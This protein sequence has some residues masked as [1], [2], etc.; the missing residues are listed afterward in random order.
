M[1]SLPPR[2]LALV[3]L[4]LAALGL[5]FWRLGAMPLF[6]D[7]AFYL[8]WADRL[9]PA[10]FDHPAGIAWLLKLSTLLGGQNE[11]GVRW[12]NALLG[13]ACV[14]LVYA[15]GRRYVSA[16]GGLIAAAAVAFGPVYVVTGRVVY[17]DALHA[18]LL[19]VNLLTL[20]P[21]FSGDRPSLWRWVWGGLALALLLNVKLSSGFYAIALGLYLLGWR[22]DLLRQPGLWLMAGVAGLG[23]LPI[24]G[25][26]LAHDWA[27]IRWAIF[28][29]QGFGLPQPGMRASLVHAWRVVTP[30]AVLLAGLAAATWLAA[31]IRQGCRA[32]ATHGRLRAPAARNPALLAVV[33][34]CLLLPI[35]LSAADSPRNLGVGL[36]AVWPLAG[37]SLSRPD[38]P[39]GLA[40]PGPL[41]YLA[42]AAGL[43]LGLVLA[44]YGVG[45]LAALLGPTRLPHNEA[46]A[47]IRA[48]AAG[49]PQFAREVSLSADRVLFAVDYSIAGQIAHYTGRPVYTAAQ[50]FQ[51]W[52]IPEFSDATVFAM[53]FIP[54]Q[55]ITDRL[56]EDFAT[57]TGPETWTYAQD[58]VAKPVFI[59]RATGRRAAMEQV[60]ADLDY[61]TLVRAARRPNRAQE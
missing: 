16:W 3:A 17:P 60:I 40:K 28:Q 9:A 35:L 43:L 51:M 21:L 44:L 52:G 45:T 48:D 36:L 24:I 15:V 29:G 10:Y 49:W 32:D 47:A 1:K 26:N 12:L 56:A 55:L 18:F 53:S 11:L 50:Q 38:E 20:A 25:W 39:G 5:R 30:P 22:R 42:H 7:E 54:P 2:S 14:P 34:A 46:S 8:L 37:L 4:T 57:V 23:L 61:L 19:L 6:G 58:D 31:T 59:W 33:G 27:M 41:M 13:T